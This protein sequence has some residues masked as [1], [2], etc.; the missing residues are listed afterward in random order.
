M[1]RGLS[2]DPE[3]ELGTLVSLEQKRGE[4]REGGPV[5][6]AGRVCP[7]WEAS[8]LTAAPKGGKY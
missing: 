4:P 1:L 5:G 7:G 8:P 2:R 6:K 3:A